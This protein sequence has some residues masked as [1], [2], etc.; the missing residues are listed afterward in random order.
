MRGSRGAISKALGRAGQ[1]HKV[2]GNVAGKIGEMTAVTPRG[3]VEE[4]VG[5]NVP[6]VPTKRTVGAN[7][8]PIPTIEARVAMSRKG[9]GQAANGPKTLRKTH[10]ESRS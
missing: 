8:P 1:I 4:A 3:P 2:G 7:V 6:A 9:P 10:A 5:A